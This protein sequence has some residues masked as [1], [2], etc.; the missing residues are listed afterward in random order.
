VGLA[1]ALPVLRCPVCAGAL[2]PVA[3][4]VRCVAGHGFDVGRGGYLNLRTGRARRIAG[5]TAVMVAARETFLGDG[6]YRP[7]TDRLAELAAVSGDRQPAPAVLEIGAGTGHHLSGVLSALPAGAVG[8]AVDVSRHAL[9]RAARAH[10]R[11]AA[12]G[13]DAAGPW[14]VADRSVT[15]LLDVFAPRNPAEMYRVLHPTGALLVVTP[16]PGHLAE[17]RGPLGLV[18]IQADKG[19]RLDERTAGRFSPEPVE[20]L[21]VPLALSLDEAVD[22]ALMGP[23]GHHR[24]PED[25]RARAEAGWPSR[26]LT[27]TARFQLRRYLPR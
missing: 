12:V 13:F 1:A 11:I 22:L 27:V 26:R 19:D 7:L 24:T 25:L 14:P 10:P 3:G 16:A 15:V 17:L 18:G 23:T 5:D 9:R 2:H 20:R 21:D 4:E 6:H 8:V